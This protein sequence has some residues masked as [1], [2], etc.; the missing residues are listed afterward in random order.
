MKSKPSK[1]ST[2]VRRSPEE[3]R[4]LIL[5][6]A[7]KVFSDHLPDV[8]GLKDV[9]REAGVSHALITHY[10]G[11]YD[12]LVEA[13][14]ERRFHQLRDELVPVL[15]GLVQSN[16]DVR[17]MLT[18]HR[19]G[20][21]RLASNPSTLRL[22]IWALLSGRV[23]ADDFFPSR[24]QGLKMLADALESRSKASRADIEFLLVASFAMATTWTFAGKALIGGLGR[25]ATKDVT[26][27]FE[28]RTALMIE[29]FLHSAEQKQRD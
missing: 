23:N 7:E 18:A 21:Q 24:M 15:I 10:F 26:D 1:K 16:A 9:A 25:K 11:T 5:D 28:E 19:H 27:A 29:Q 4:A 6:A 8:V 2:R 20:I 17:E 3:A 22:A 13:T 14:L 12:A